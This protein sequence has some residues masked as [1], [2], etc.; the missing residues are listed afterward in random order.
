MNEWW[1]L[2]VLPVG[3]Y[4]VGSIPFSF[5]VGKASGVDLRTEG[6]GNPGAGNLRRVVGFPAALTAGLL[7]GFKGLFIV[8]ALL[9]K[10]PDA[11]LVLTA[12]ATVVGHNWSIFMGFRSGRGL[13]TAA[14]VVLAMSPLLLL[15]PLAW[16]IAGWWIGG[17]VA[18]FIGW[19]ALP[20]FAALLDVPQVPQVAVPVTAGLAVLILVRRMQGNPDAIHGWHAAAHRMVFDT[21]RA[22]SK[23]DG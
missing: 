10:V 18:G 22:V 11:V 4:L 19:T 17:G 7:D 1:L 14:C 20:I 15:W 21:D 2:L 9:G 12:L 8:L 13:A 3:A 5:L 23:L 16:G 6:T